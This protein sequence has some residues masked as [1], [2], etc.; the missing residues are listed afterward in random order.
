MSVLKSLCKYVLVIFLG[1]AYFITR[2]GNMF[3]YSVIIRHTYK[4]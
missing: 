1:V 3:R 4:V 2:M